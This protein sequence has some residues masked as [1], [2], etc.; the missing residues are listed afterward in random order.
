MSVF[1]PVLYEVASSSKMYVLG[2][3]GIVEISRA[4]TVRKDLKLSRNVHV[5]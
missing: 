5:N 3:V 4:E 1:R 2:R